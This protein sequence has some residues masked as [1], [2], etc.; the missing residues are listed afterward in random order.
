MEQSVLKKLKRFTTGHKS[1]FIISIILSM[2]GVAF[3]VLPFLAVAQIAIKLVEG[4]QDTTYYLCAVAIILCGYVMKSVF[5]TLS[6]RTSHIATYA[7]LKNIRLEMVSKLNRMPMGDIMAM[8]SG[9]LKDIIVDR[10]E[11][12]ERTLAHMIP[13]FTGNFSIS[14]FVVIYL[15]VINLRRKPTCLRVG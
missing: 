5:L 9:Q 11:G 6:T 10:V 14:F 13:E 8:P 15:F 1:E 12:F 3:G 2:L 7:I 4:S